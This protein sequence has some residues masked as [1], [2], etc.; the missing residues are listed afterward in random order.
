MWFLN[1]F[2]NNFT[3]YIFLPTEQKPNL[4]HSSKAVLFYCWLSRANFD[5]L[6]NSTCKTLVLGKQY[7]DKW[8]IF[9]DFQFYTMIL[10]W[11]LMQFKAMLCRNRFIEQM[12]TT[13][14]IKRCHK[15]FSTILFNRKMWFNPFDSASLA[16]SH[17]AILWRRKNIILQKLVQTKTGD[18][19]HVAVSSL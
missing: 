12:R 3:F 10:W 8:Q 13:W 11:S 6:K 7:T 16:T 17:F 15:L 4:K 18:Y 19:Q 9:M 2:L 5:S 1:N 14:V